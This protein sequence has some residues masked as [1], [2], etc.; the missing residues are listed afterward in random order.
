MDLPSL[1]ESLPQGPYGFV[2][3][4]L[5]GTL[6]ND[7]H[8]ILRTPLRRLVFAFR[9]VW[10]LL[11]LYVQRC[12]TI[13]L[14]STYVFCS[15]K[16]YALILYGCHY[17]AR[18][19]TRSGTL[20]FWLGGSSVEPFWTDSSSPS[21]RSPQPFFVTPNRSGIL[22]PTMYSRNPKYVHQYY[23]YWSLLTLNIYL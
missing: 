16:K 2:H 23:M 4:S 15:R 8:D 19:P 12:T 21:Y 7:I 22:L 3:P 10:W 5:W 17:P 11:G 18:M 6:A 13:L 20:P 1:Y 14:P 9:A